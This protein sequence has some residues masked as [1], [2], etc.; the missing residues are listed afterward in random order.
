MLLVALCCT[1]IVAFKTQSK[2]M[3][4]HASSGIECVFIAR[5]IKS[6]THLIKQFMRTR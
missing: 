4:V 5:R 2:N 1:H 3:Y 6:H